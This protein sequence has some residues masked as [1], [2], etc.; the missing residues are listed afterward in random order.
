MIITRD[1]L[2]ERRQL[3]TAQRDKLVATLNACHGA[4]QDVEQLL[5]VLDAPEPE[6]G[7]LVIDPKDT[8]GVI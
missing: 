6:P 3:F 4:I 7:V 1:L 2:T 8:V 5:A